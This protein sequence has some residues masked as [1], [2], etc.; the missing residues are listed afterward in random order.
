MRLTKWITLLV[1]SLNILSCKSKEDFA[2]AANGQ[3]LLWQVTG[4]DLQK[5][6]YIYGTM[7]ILCD[8]DAKP[9]KTLRAVIKN[10]DEIY[11]EIDLDELGELFAGVSKTM[12]RN[13]TTLADLYTPDEYDRVTAFFHQHDMG[14]QLEVMK[15]M[16]PMLTSASLYQLIMPCSAT[17]G[18]EISI[19]KE[20][21]PYHKEVRGLET[22]AFQASLI[23]SISYHAQA[24]ELLQ[25]VDSLEIYKQNLTEMLRI[26]KAQDVEQLYRFSLQ[27][28]MS[29]SEVQD[30]MLNKRNQN[31]AKQ[32]P[33][34]TK[35]KS[36]L[37]A[38]GAG[39]L[40]GVQGLLNLLKQQG[41]TLTPL[42]NTNL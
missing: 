24:K 1:S 11:F 12:M 26:Y 29:S 15:R 5:P 7:H 37:I 34:I 41:Y 2:I 20:S 28:E 14:A 4:K 10:V 42:E 3:S 31:W 22:A 23:D 21:K 30:M 16:Q 18:M 27:G 39:H 25:M 40:G 17:N 35:N 38:V 19:I 9:G 32:F 33:E 36:L 13:D 6:V 8:A